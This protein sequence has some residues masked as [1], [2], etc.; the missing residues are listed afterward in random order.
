M[1]VT[2]L[3]NKSKQQLIMSIEKLEYLPTAPLP[4]GY[5]VRCY[6]PGDEKAWEKIIKAAFERER[7]F[8]EKVTGDEYF[9]PERVLFACHREEGPVATACA[10]HVPKT[11]EHIGYLYM[12]GTLPAHQEKGLGYA[13]CLAAINQM[14]RDNKTAALLVTDSFR[15]PAIKIY[16]KLGFQP[17]PVHPSHLLVWD[18]ILQQ[19][20][21]H[22]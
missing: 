17:Q 6:Q 2:K 5:S 3:D 1:A 8:T 14:I 21:K 13:V 4:D 18:G 10:W 16:L 9:R 7:S 15:L 22:R 11:P 19:L 12:V 20:A